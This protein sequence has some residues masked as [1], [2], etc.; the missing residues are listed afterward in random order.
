[1]D[2]LTRTIGTVPTAAAI[3][4]SSERTHSRRR[5]LMLKLKATWRRC[6]FS[7]EMVQIEFGEPTSG[8]GAGVSFRC[9]TAGVDPRLNVCRARALYAPLHVHA[10][11]AYVCLLGV[12]VLNSLSMC[13][14]SSGWERSSTLCGPCWPLAYWIQK[15][16]SIC[17]GLGSCFAAPLSRYL[18]YLALY[19]HLCILFAF[20]PPPL[21]LAH[22]K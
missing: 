1:M 15:R 3:R 5:F 10:C 16:L 7:P 13:D 6:T 8:C 14:E 18:I 20:V 17:Q 22:P 19:L 12:S 2:G 9:Q 11:G 21:F 4:M